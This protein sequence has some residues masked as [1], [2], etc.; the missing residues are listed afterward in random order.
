M[1]DEEQFKAT[2][3]QKYQGHFDHYYRLHQL[4]QASLVNYRAF[5]NTHYETALQYISPRAFKSFDS[6]RRLCEVALCEDAAVIL[7]CLMNLMAITRWI[8]VEPEKRAKKFLG[9]FFVELNERVEEYPEK[10]SAE[11]IT[12]IRKRFESEK[13]Q[14]EFV[15]RKGKPDFARAWYQP[16]VHSIYDLFKEV[17]LGPLYETDYRALSGTEHSDVMAYLPMFRNA[18]IVDGER[19]LEIQNDQYV[20]KFLRGAFQYFADILGTC[21]KTIPLVDPKALHEIVAAGLEFYKADAIKR[22]VPRASGP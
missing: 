15:N 11:A 19:K 9:W 14:F 22:E 1:M 3:I 20:R 2:I 13:S 16:D 4:A 8:S 10:F 7:R 6:I 12:S 5:T 18:E 17:D 21:N